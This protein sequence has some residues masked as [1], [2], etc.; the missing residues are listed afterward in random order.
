MDTLT[1][2]GGSLTAEQKEHY[3][4]EGFVVLPGLIS[5]EELQPIKD[6][7]SEKVECIAQELAAQGLISDLKENL[8]FEHRLAHLFEGLRE[9]EFNK[10]GRSWRERRPGFYDLMSNPKILDAVESL[11]G[12]EIFSN[13][14]YNVRPKVPNVAA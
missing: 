14:V 4:I 1:L 3:E 11:I 6:S 2:P 7:L 12:P 5:P 10:Y 13:P 8:P 9:Q